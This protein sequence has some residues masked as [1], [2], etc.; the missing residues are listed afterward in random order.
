MASSYRVIMFSA[1]WESHSE[2]N[3][4]FQ[5]QLP[6]DWPLT[7]YCTWSHEVHLNDMARNVWQ[8]DYSVWHS[9]V[10]SWLGQYHVYFFQSL[11]YLVHFQPVV[12]AT[13][14][15]ASFYCIKKGTQNVSIRNNHRSE[16]YLVF[17]CR[18]LAGDIEI[19][20]DTIIRSKIHSN[21][22]IV[23]FS[24]SII[25]LACPSDPFRLPQLCKVS[26]IITCDILWFQSNNVVIL[27]TPCIRGKIGRSRPHSGGGSK[28]IK[29]NALAV[30][31]VTTAFDRQGVD[32]RWHL[33]E[34]NCRF[35][36]NI[37]VEPPKKC[38]VRTKCLIA[39]M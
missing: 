37:F 36:R 34:S 6:S 33:F 14:L 7:P 26:F 8:Q 2:K 22:Y 4:S 12:N 18:N 3:Y 35:K 16:C 27:N 38:F 24:F 28:S 11:L 39:A 9:I 5:L 17:C 15:D 29:D 32:I 21:I 13:Y 31:H 10:R 30:H 23:D 20:W 19:H 1:L 25:I